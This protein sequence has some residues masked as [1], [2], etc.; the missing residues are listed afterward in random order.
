MVHETLDIVKATQ[1]K[2]EGEQQKNKFQR[3]D[4]TTRAGRKGK[5]GEGHSKDCTI[6]GEDVENYRKI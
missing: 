6:E 3:Y 2:G 4:Q 5:F 1:A